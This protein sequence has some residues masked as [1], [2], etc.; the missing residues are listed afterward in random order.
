MNQTVNGK[1][2][3]MS[4]NFIETACLLLRKFFKILS[5]KI[6]KL[7]LPI[8]DFINETTQIPCLDNQ[9]ALTKSSY[10]EDLCYMAS[11]FKKE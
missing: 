8:L 6:S 9:K 4:N 5:K 11:Y 7:P 10:F 3:A 1:K 2:K